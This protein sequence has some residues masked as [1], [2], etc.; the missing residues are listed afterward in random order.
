MEKESLADDIILYHGDSLRIL[1]ALQEESV[2]AV[3]AELA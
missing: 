1:S 3:L 2:D